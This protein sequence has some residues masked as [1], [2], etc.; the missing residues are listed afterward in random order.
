M[1]QTT[2]TLGVQKREKHVYLGETGGHKKE[3]DLGLRVEGWY[4]RFLGLL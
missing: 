2:N 3:G 4:T 1:T